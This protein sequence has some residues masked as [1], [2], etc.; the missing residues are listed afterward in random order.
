MNWLKIIYEFERLVFQLTVLVLLAPKT[1]FKMAVN[2][3]WFVNY[4]VIES[5]K[6]PEQRFDEYVSPIVYWI[7]FSVLLLAANILFAEF[8]DSV[9]NTAMGYLGGKTEL[10]NVL[11]TDIKFDSSRF[12]QA[13]ILSLWFPLVFAAVSVV[14][15]TKNISR[16][17]MEIPFYIQCYAFGTFVAIYTILEIP[18]FMIGVGGFSI[19]GF[20]LNYIALGMCCCWMIWFQNIFLVNKSIMSVAFRVIIILL[21]AFMAILLLYGTII[22]IK[23]IPKGLLEIFSK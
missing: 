8:I 21:S 1:L 22:V 16:V 4:I 23:D 19:G 13:I 2:P 14:W 11:W 7:V 6:E 18:F 20:R 3:K 17:S 5:K 10:P 9:I 12:G 15:T